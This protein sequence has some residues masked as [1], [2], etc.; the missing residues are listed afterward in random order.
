MPREVAA[1]VGYSTAWVREVVRRWN[2]SGR[3]GMTD[4]RRSLP[5]A[6]P[7]LSLDEQQDLAIALEQAAC[8]WRLVERAERGSLDAGKTRTPSGSPTRLGL[9][10]APGLQFAGPSS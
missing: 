8:R 6:K 1:Q 5:G 2:E 4:H 9:L 3:Q 10:A 7:L